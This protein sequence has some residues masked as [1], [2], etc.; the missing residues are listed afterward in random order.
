[1]IMGSLGQAQDLVRPMA[2]EIAARMMTKNAE[3]QAALAS[4]TSERTYRLEYKGTG[5]ERWAEIVVR[6]EYL[7]PDRNS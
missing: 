3:R 6:A 2:E 4:Y 7:V 1:M 5:G